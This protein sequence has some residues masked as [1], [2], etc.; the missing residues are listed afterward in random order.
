M[1]QFEIE[2]QDAKV[3]LTSDLEKSLK[4][5]FTGVLHR[6]DGTEKVMDREAVA[7]FLLE[8]SEEEAVAL[9]GL[10]SRND[11]GSQNGFDMERDDDGVPLVFLNEYKCKEDGFTWTDKWDC[12]V[13]TECEC[14]GRDFSP[15]KSTWLGPDDTILQSVWYALP[16]EPLKPEVAP[17]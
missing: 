10:D 7:Y 8:L 9:I 4:G 12:G 3:I 2:R 11:L 15:V 13:D 14:C 5:R 17:R 1:P 16:G 6:A